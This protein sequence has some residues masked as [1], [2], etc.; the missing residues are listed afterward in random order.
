MEKSFQPQPGEFN[1]VGM[2][3]AWSRTTRYLRAWCDFE[4]VRSVQSLI[5][6]RGVTKRC[7]IIR[8]WTKCSQPPSDAC[9][10]VWG[11]SGDPRRCIG[12]DSN[13][14]R[15]K[16]ATQPFTQSLDESL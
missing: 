9:V 2:P 5:L 6:N 11:Y 13:V 14:E 8:M 7:D 15:I 12:I 16:R 1:A 4:S 10:D 3:I